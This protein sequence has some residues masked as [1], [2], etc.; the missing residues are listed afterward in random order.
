M[1]RVGIGYDIHA[2]SDEAANYIILGGEKIPYGRRIIAHSDGDVIFHSL[3]DALLGAVAQGSIGVHFSNRD[4][5]W[6]DASSDIFVQY[7][8]SFVKND[9]YKVNNVDLI[10]ICQEPKIM[11]HALNIKNNISK[12]LE[13]EITQV[14]VKAVTGEGIGA[15]GRGEGIAA[16]VIVSLVKR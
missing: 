9:G 10:V 3:T 15:I 4:D 8:Y 11:P 6:K 16:Q 14:N 13:L 12:L 7:A 2:F 1:F 5:R